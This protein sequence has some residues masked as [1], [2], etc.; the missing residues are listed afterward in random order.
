MPL[1]IFRHLVERTREGAEFVLRANRDAGVEVAAGKLA[2]AAR[3]GGKV[4][5]H[6]VRD[7]DDADE[8]QGD[9]EHAETEIAHRCAP[10]LAQRLADRPGDPEDDPRRRATRDDDP[11]AGSARSSFCRD[12]CRALDAKRL[13]PRL[14][15]RL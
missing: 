5:R 12:Q 4:L 6:A 9:H 3:E 2:H 8:R 14:V 13:E 7:R 15:V 10:D 11:V 1:E